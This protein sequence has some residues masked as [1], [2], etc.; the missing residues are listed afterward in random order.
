MHILKN[1]GSLCAC[2]R[3]SSGLPSP[4]QHK[5]LLPK[6]SASTHPHYRT[7]THTVADRG[8][9]PPFKGH[10]P[11]PTCSRFFPQGAPK[12]SEQ[13]SACAYTVN[14]LRSLRE[15]KPAGHCE[16]SLENKHLVAEQSRLEM[17]HNNIH[18]VTGAIQQLVTIKPISGS[19]EG[20]R[21]WHG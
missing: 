13:Q 5:A 8:C 18:T 16:Q 6:D 12:P 14:G 11:A 15:T 19:P 21:V 9:S 1:A 10:P 20:V 2:E 3:T 4:L 17:S 7:A